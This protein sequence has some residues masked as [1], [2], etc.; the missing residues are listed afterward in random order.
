M[1]VVT[2]VLGAVYTPL[3]K[4]TIH[5]PANRLRLALCGGAPLFLLLFLFSFL[6]LSGAG[7]F[8]VQL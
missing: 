1:T 2:V 5:S 7:G 8:M 3:F 4:G 6:V